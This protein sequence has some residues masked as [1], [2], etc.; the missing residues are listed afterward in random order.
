[1][2]EPQK[3]LPPVPGAPSSVVAVVSTPAISAIS[4]DFQGKVGR[5]HPHKQE[6]GY[7]A[8]LALATHDAVF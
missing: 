3:C 5:R 2:E 8:N 6:W 7:S 4:P 1:M